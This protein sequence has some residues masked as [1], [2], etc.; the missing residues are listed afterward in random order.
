MRVPNIDSNYRNQNFGM[1]LRIRTPQEEMALRKSNDLVLSEFSSEAATRMINSSPVIKANFEKL[2]G[3]VEKIEPRE[4]E[5]VAE[6]PKW[7]SAGRFLYS[8]KGKFGDVPMHA[9]I[10]LETATED[11]L[12]NFV[13]LINTHY[14]AWSTKNVL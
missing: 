5:L 14:R 10:D 8:L 7:M 3:L 2:Q 13:Q 1:K 6:K 12:K 11:A 9:T 4:A